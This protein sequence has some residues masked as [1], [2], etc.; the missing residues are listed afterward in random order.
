VH[1]CCNV[2]RSPRRKISCLLFMLD[3]VVDRYDFLFQTVLNSIGLEIV[4]V[5]DRNARA[6]RKS[7]QLFNLSPRHKN[8]HPVI[9]NHKQPYNDHGLRIRI[10]WSRRLCWPPDQVECDDED[11]VISW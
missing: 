4:Q 3:L 1:T 7:S 8:R 9:N 2:A 6:K 11:S 5:C 10:N